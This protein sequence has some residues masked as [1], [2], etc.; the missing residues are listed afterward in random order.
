M[1][2]HN[3]SLKPKRQSG[4]VLTGPKVMFFIISKVFWVLVQ[5]L[6]LIGLLSVFGLFL[7]SEVIKAWRSF[8]TSVR[9]N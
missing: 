9:V 2:L 8:W 4:W 6:S 3:R 7:L 1:D 5:P